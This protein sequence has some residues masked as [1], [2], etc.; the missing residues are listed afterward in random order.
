MNFNNIVGDA[1][2][3][4]HL[5][6]SI[7]ALVTGLMVLINRKGT[8]FHKRTGYVYAAAMLVLNATAF[9]I[10]RLYGSFGIF[11]WFAVFSCLTL[12]AGLYPVLTKRSKN[13]LLLHFSF[14]YWS[15]IGL[16]CAFMAEVF[17]RLPSIVLTASGEPMTIFYKMV[18]IAIAVTMTVGIIFFRKHSPKWT[19]Q[20]QRR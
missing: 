15:V 12:L 2:G 20:Y 9:M 8:R 3:L 1:V 17:T 16:Y 19:K 7:I 5:I 11:H 13:Y 14:M 10:Y 6:A 18:G 4:V